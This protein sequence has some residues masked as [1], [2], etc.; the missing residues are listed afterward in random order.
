ME[1][2]ADD[3]ELISTSLKNL[4]L[5]NDIVVCKDGVDALNYL[6]SSAETPFLILSDINMPRM[7]GI[8]FKQKIDACKVLKEKCI[9]FI[10]ISTSNN[11]GLARSACGLNVQ[12]LFEKGYSYQQ[13]LET[14]TIILKYWNNTTH[15]N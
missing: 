12:G 7:D 6:Y 8:T 1:D 13:L 10:F 14:L 4:G 15:L 9:P 11:G 5:I 3:Q 2:D